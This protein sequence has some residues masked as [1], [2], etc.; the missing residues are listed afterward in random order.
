M[1]KASDNSH[2]D[3]IGSVIMIRGRGTE[4]AARDDIVLLLPYLFCKTL[5]WQVFQPLST[6]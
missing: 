6:F 2:P 1:T 4:A 5:S 3:Y